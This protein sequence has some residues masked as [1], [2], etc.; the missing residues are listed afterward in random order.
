M[1]SRK[2]SQAKTIT[3]VFVIL[4]FSWLQ[5]ACSANVSSPTPNANIGDG[6]LLSGKPCSAPCFYNITPGITAEKQALEIF[7]SELDL[8]DC[9]RWEKNDN[10]VDRGMRCSNIGITFNDSSIVNVVSFQPSQI[11]TVDQVIKKYGFPDAVLVTSINP[12][13]KQIGT[14]S[15]MFYYDSMNVDLSL[16][17]QNS[18]AFDLKPTTLIENIGYS[19]QNSYKLVRR[20]SQKWNGYGVYEQYNP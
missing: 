17:E 20:Y 19:D 10:G 4:I 6:G 5:S 12:S 14:V 8:K 11:I 3:V 7:S 18:G 9:D 15:M 1:T 13:N 2:A 16:A